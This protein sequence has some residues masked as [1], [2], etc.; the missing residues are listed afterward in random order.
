MNLGRRWDHNN[1]YHQYL[2]NQ[3][4]PAIDR[5]LDVGCGYGEFAAHL[6]QRST[7]V[8]AVDA[9]ADVIQMAQYQHARLDHL[10]FI[11]GDFLEMDLP[12]EH[13]HVVT[14]LAAIHHMALE[15]AL[16]KIKQVLQPGGILA[17]LGLYREATASDHVASV[18]GILAHTIYSRFI[19]RD[20]FLTKPAQTAPITSPTTTLAEIKSVANTTLPG[21]RIRRHLLWRYSLIWE[22][23]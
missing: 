14:S 11:Q 7:Y 21:A 17:I 22:K 13:Y 2:L 20:I 10:S 15:P 6:A 3:L 12:R 9:D 19:Y 4:P 23:R 1:H 5:V 8:H 16:E 18:T